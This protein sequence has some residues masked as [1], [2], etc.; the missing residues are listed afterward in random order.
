MYISFI[1]RDG[2]KSYQDELCNL[3]KNSLVKKNIAVMEV[4]Y[5]QSVTMITGLLAHVLRNEGYKGEIDLEEKEKSIANMLRKELKELLPER[6]KVIENSVFFQKQPIQVVFIKNNV[7]SNIGENDHYIRIDGS[8]RLGVVLGSSFELVIKGT[9]GTPDREIS[10]GTVTEISDKIV[11][12]IT[13]KF[14]GV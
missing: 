6:I 13:N 8:P 3:L 7:I 14:R 5:N 12:E 4:D 2:G 11:E 9:F 1:C 10:T